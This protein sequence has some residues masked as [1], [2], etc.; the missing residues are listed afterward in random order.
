M[1]QNQK[2]KKPKFKLTENHKV[3]IGVIAVVLSFQFLTFTGFCYGE[4]SYLSK[5]ELLDRY[6]SVQSLNEDQKIKSAAKRGL[7]YPG[8]CN[9]TQ[10]QDV[11]ARLLGFYNFK[12]EWYRE[13]KIRPDKDKYRMGWSYM[14]SCG[15][16]KISESHIGISKYFFDGMI[17]KNRKNWEN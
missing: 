17:K 10:R 7:D 14:N 11:L 9:I 15:T 3:W 12:I 4:L 13:N 5:R 2:S 6:L 8:C 1:S 16:K